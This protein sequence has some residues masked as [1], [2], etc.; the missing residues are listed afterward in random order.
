MSVEAWFEAESVSKVDLNLNQYRNSDLCRRSIWCQFSFKFDFKSNYCRKSNENRVVPRLE[1]KPVWNLNFKPIWCWNLKSN[2]FRNSNEG[3]LKSE[4]K[5]IKAKSL[6]KVN[7]KSSRTS[8]GNYYQWSSSILSQVSIET[9]F[10]IKSVSK[11]GWKNQRRYSIWSKGSIVSRF[12]AV[13][14]SKLNW[15]LN[16]FRNSIERNL[17]SNGKKIE[18][19]SMSKVDL[20]PIQYRKS[21]WSLSVSKLLDLK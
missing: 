21:I 3:K 2:Q 11:L 15:K 8:I 16:M 9:Q 7:R 5:K 20:N 4:R 13:P 12:E 10:E 17:I 14:A 19:I 6:S 18:A 1:M